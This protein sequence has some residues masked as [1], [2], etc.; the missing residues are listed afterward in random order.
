MKTEYS[1]VVSRVQQEGSV[2]SKSDSSE[3]CSMMTSVLYVPIR[4]VLFI[5]VGR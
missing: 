5:T 3:L 1:D 4:C 2:S